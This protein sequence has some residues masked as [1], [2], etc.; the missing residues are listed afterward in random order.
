MAAPQQRRF[1]AELARALPEM[2]LGI[3]LP[4]EAQLDLYRASLESRD[5]L[6]ARLRTH[7]PSASRHALA[8][9]AD[10]VVAARQR[11]FSAVAL[12]E[13]LHARM[14]DLWRAST[15]DDEVRRLLR[16]YHVRY[17]FAGSLERAAFGP[18]ADT[19]AVFP[20]VLARGRTVIYE[21]PPEVRQ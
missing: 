6:L 12:S 8:A 9:H 2:D 19:F 11:A 13:K 10:A 1:F 3:G 18:T 15:V 20:R 17:V 5:A 16:L 4:R 7:L 21:V 14:T